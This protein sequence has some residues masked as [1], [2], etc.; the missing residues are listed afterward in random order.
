MYDFIII[1]GGM[2]GLY[3]AYKI[4]KIDPTKN[5]LIL[6]S[7]D[8]L[9]GRAG[10]YDFHGQQ[11]A[12]GA[13]VVRKKKD[14]VFIKLLKELDIPYNDFIT[15]T[16]Y[17]KTIEPA[18]KVKEMFLYLR[19]EY[20][21]EK[22]KQK[23]FKQYAKPKLETKYGKDA[24]FYFTTCA[25]YTDYEYE[26]AYDT[27]HYYGFEDNF[28]SWAGMGIS[29]NQIVGTLALRV[30]SQ[31]IRKSTKVQ[32][33]KQLEAYNDSYE[34]VCDETTSFLCKK[35]II[36]TT[37]DTV[38]KL[39]PNKRIFNQIKGQPFL[40]MYGLFSKESIPILKNY[41]TT[42]TVVP[43]PLHKIIPINSDKGIYM[44]VYTDNE[45][46]ELLKPHKENNK[47]NR[48]MLSRLIE[49]GLGIE[50]KTLEME[51]MVDFYWD[52]GTHY[53]TPMKGGFK[54]RKEF[55]DIAQCPEENIRVVG[56]MI[57][58]NQGWTEGALESVENVITPNWI[59]C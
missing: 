23:T 24:Y 17:S 9:G 50:E 38:K 2:A 8:H 53:Y 26:C 56:E 58:M 13:G 18:C 33:I 46:A 4:R 47:E 22:D 49:L 28:S 20:N 55:C 35:V 10:N 30:G 12:I 15:T 3:T 1:G 34:I 29:W 48:E 39:L 36:A 16:N 59:K 32:N 45:G 27:L 37:I 7:N 6:E 40:R 19:N 14:K 5:I 11:V 52:I 43:G 57:S 31:Q 54:N 21:K 42:T 51:D 41:C 25:G 44:I